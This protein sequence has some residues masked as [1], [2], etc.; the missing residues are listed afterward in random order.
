M[1][2]PRGQQVAL[3][4]DFENVVFGAGATLPDRA[5]RWQRER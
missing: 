1:P 3:L 2:V 5:S 4:I